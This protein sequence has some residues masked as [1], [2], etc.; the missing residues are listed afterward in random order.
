MNNFDLTGKFSLTFNKALLGLKFLDDLDKGLSSSGLVL[1]F[2]IEYGNQPGRRRLANDEVNVFG[3][4]NF[5]QFKLRR[6][7]EDS[8]LVDQ[9]NF[10][11]TSIGV[12]DD[13]LTFTIKFDSPGVVSIGSKPDKLLIEI[14]NPSFFSS[15]DSGTTIEAGYTL[16]FTLPRMID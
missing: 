8:A 12:V 7:G 10:N 4:S 6:G 9:L 3:L 15:S 2:E 11:V 14:V 5:L 1:D 13:Q 16:E